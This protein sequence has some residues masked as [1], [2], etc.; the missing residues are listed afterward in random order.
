MFHS[1][2]FNW[3][4]L[5]IHHK[6]FF[7]CNSFKRKGMDIPKQEKLPSSQFFLFLFIEFPVLL[8]KNHKYNRENRPFLL[9]RHFY[10]L[11]EKKY[12]SFLSA[13]FLLIE[14]SD[15]IPSFR[16]DILVIPFFHVFLTDRRGQ[17][18]SLITAKKKNFQ[19]SKHSHKSNSKE[20][21]GYCKKWRPIKQI[22]FI[23]QMM[24]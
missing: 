17:A 9:C 15:Y 24:Q 18:N 7:T 21:D 19:P 1:T 11:N 16:T 12:I 23:I 13:A 5:C 14:Q 10:C 4:H 2:I 8:L 20:L 3:R 22:A 6:V